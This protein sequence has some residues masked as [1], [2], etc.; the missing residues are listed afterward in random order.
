MAWYVEFTMVVKARFPFPLVGGKVLQKGMDLVRKLIETRL[1]ELGLSMAGVSR[2]LPSAK[3]VMHNDSYLFQFLMKGSPREL[4][5]RERHTLAEI[6]KV[7]E[8]QLRG[9]SMVLEGRKHGQNA[10]ARKNT[11][12]EL[13]PIPYRGVLE[14]TI[15]ADQSAIGSVVDL[16]VFGTSVRGDDGEQILSEMAV[17]WVVRPPMLARVADAYAVIVPRNKME[18]VVKA[19]SIVMFHPYLPPRVGDLC[20]FRSLRNG[21]TYVLGAEY[22]GETSTT[23]QAHHYTPNRDFT[24]KKVEWQACHRSVG[25]YFT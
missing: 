12:A 16:P 11:V 6:L 20:L 5:E 22:R 9:P 19:G 17:D 13:S 18:P 15:R 4:A 21:L 3:G 1:K 23:W 2:M 14:S 8:D 24:L 25:V 10:A 7:P